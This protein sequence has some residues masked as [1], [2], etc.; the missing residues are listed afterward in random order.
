[1]N[2]FCVINNFFRYLTKCKAKEKN[3]KAR[4]ILKKINFTFLLL[5]SVLI[6]RSEW[7][8]YQIKAVSMTIL[9][10]IITFS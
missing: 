2:R 4:V 10:Y 1:M 3:K 6:I 8:A 7:D 9:E 5:A